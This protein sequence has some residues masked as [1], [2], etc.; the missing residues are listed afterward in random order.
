[1]AAAAALTLSIVSGLAVWSLST[2][3][4]SS[5]LVTRSSIPLPPDVALTGAFRVLALSPDGSH[6][7]YS[8]NSRLYLRALNQSEAMPI[9]GTEGGA[10]DPFFSPDGE[11]IGF[12]ADG[13]LK[14]INIGGGAAISLCE[15]AFSSV[16]GG[17]SWNVDDSILFA[18][19]G[20][21]ILR[22]SAAGGTREVLIPLEDV[23]EVGLVP[24]ALPG[25]K[26]VLFTL[27][28][29]LN[30]STA[31]IVVHSLETGE[32]KV[33]IEGGKGARYLSTG[34]LVYFF[35][36]T[37]LAVPFDV[38]KL[39]V[40][41]GPVPMTEGISTVDASPAA[42]FSVS[43]T[44]SL[45]YLA[46]NFSRRRVLVWVDRQGNEEVLKAEPRSGYNQL[47]ISP[48]GS[49]VAVTDV[50]TRDI[51]SWDFAREIMKRLT[52][53]PAS[54]LYPVWTL[55]G[56]RLV[57][58]SN[59]DGPFNLYWKAADGTG[60]VDRLT[61]APNRQYAN[62][63]TPD[64]N[65][66]L[67]H[68]AKLSG[69][70]LAVLS[71]DGAS[72]PLLATES[73]ERSAELSPNGKWLAYESDASGQYEIYV[74]PYPNVDDGNRR[75]DGGTRPLW[76][77]DGRELFYLAAWGARSF[78]QSAASIMVMPR[79]T[80]TCQTDYLTAINYHPQSGWFDEGPFVRKGAKAP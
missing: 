3:N 36:G 54:D 41:G 77:R 13:Q 65:H 69:G 37:L 63:F 64:G 18:E 45:V 56:Q 58:T 19:P 4:P 22:V 38:E 66:L 59:R 47:R 78:K 35:E 46:G 74:R 57:F 2:D 11:W 33:L 44:G 39:E 1:M 20:T 9:R 72:V 79:E 6:L 60:A 14:K 73:D 10:R 80:I 24:Q 17:A 5:P 26:A 75:R 76:A 16:R 25:G 61:E 70:D 42:P 31:Q 52:F 27:G 8:A 29:G 15:I 7:V 49:S 51:W 53:A 68:D 55:D 48:D 71:L 34:H 21:G 43:D 40:T 50:N 12:S 30:W 28:D 23:G 62:A 67:Y 32:R